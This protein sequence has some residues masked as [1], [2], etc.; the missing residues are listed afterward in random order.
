MQVVADNLLR[1]FTR[2]AM[3]FLVALTNPPVVPG[4]RQPPGSTNSGV[5]ST[6]GVLGNTAGTAGGAPGTPGAGGGGKAR[7]ST[8]SQSGT[9]EDHEANGG[10]Q[11]QQQQQGPSIG[12]IFEMLLASEPNVAQVGG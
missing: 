4:A 3:A 7:R 9:G 10:A 6:A 12:P 8:H 1:E 11:Q 2:E 5:G